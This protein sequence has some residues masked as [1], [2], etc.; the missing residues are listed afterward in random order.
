MVKV[1]KKGDERPEVLVRRF[2]REV[3]QSGIMTIAKKKRYF[4]KDLNRGLRRKSAI[5]RNSIASLKR[6]Y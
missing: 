5:R 2:N 4:E 3:Q 1:E 6:G